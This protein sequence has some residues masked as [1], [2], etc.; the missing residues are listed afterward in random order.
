[1][2]LLPARLGQGCP[3]RVGQLQAAPRVDRKMGVLSI[4]LAKEKRKPAS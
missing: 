3:G 2:P 4:R 1:M